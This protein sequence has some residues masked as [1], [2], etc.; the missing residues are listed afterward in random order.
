VDRLE[1]EV[2]GCCV[3]DVG[4][5]VGGVVDLEVDGQVGRGV[6]LEERLK[7]PIFGGDAMMFMRISWLD[8]IYGMGW[9]F[10]S[11]VFGRFFV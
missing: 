2:L 6:V 8:W 7:R 9:L 1:V 5:D 4:G 3:I 11:K 10:L